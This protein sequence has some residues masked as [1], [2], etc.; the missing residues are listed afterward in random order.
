MIRVTRPYVA[1]TKGVYRVYKTVWS[2]VVTGSFGDISKIRR[3]IWIGHSFMKKTLYTPIF[4][5]EVQYRPG[6]I[7]E[8]FQ[9][10]PL[11]ING[12]NHNSTISAYSGISP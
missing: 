12:K 10:A 3:D 11:K 4:D 8:K 9:L 7:E 2:E 1:L 5:F 6:I